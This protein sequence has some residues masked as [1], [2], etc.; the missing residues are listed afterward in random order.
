MDVAFT[1]FIA[2]DAPKGVWVD[3]NTQNAHVNQDPFANELMDVF[4]GTVESYPVYTKSVYSSLSIPE[5]RDAIQRYDNVV[6]TGVVAECCVLS[7]A[8]ELID[9]GAH[10][11]YL[12]DAVAGIDESTEQ[13]VE[14]V[15]KG[16]EPLHVNIMTTSEYMN[17]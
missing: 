17:Q 10:V 2:T 8:M 16:L 1:K 11:I 14:V 13:A 15:L 3:Y 5:I 12:K 9:S 7:T 4:D 6:L